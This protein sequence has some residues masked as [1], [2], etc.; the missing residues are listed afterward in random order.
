MAAAGWACAD[1]GYD[2]TWEPENAVGTLSPANDTRTNFILL[3][4]DR[5]GTKV[6]DPSAMRK[7][8]VP[9][10]FPYAVMIDRLTPARESE[11]QQSYETDLAG[12][13]LTENSDYF[14][15]DSGFLALCHS[16][17]SGAAQFESAL[18]ADA[19]VPAA[20]KTVL[21]SSRQQIAKACDNAGEM[22]FDLSGV[23]TPEGRAFAHYLEGTRLFYAEVPATADSEFAAVEHPSS[24][25]LTETASYMRFRSLLSLAMKTSLG[26]YGEMVEP[27]KRDQAAISRAD[28]AR[29]QYLAAF[30]NGRYA[31]SAQNL[32]RR[33]AWL[34]GDKATLGAAYS[35][36]LQA[37][38]AAGQLP[39]VG[40]IEE[41][42]R[43]I[44]PSDNSAGV[45]D[46]SLLAV[47]DLMRLRPG[48]A[49]YDKERSCC[50][51]WLSRAELDAQKR[52]FASD[53]GLYGY[54][55]AG[56]AFYHRHQP[57]EVLSLI[58]DAAHQARFSYTQFSRQVLRGFAL[59]ALG[60][61]NARGFWLSLLPGA[62]QP[63]QR[64]VVELAIFQ[65][66]KKA[67]VVGRLLET[68]SP[69]LHP[70]IR[71]KVIEDDAGPDLLR[72]QASAGAT[73]QQ[74]EVA[75]YL[76]LANELHHGWYRE[77]LAD[78]KLVG[79]RKQPGPDDYSSS[80]SVADYDPKYV[81]ELG[82]PPLDVFADGG[83]DTLQAC[84]NIQITA[85]NLAADPAAI[86]PRLCLG[87]F[88]RK[89][90]L[91][92]WGE[93]YDGSSGLVLKSRNGFPGT[94]LQRIDIYRSVI[95][96]PQASADDKA[97]ALN[98][99]I[100]CYAPAGNS[101]C[102]IDQEDLK[103]RK[104][105]YLELKSK[106]PDSPWAKDLKTYW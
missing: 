87:E 92:G 90:G 106:Y 54:L 46:P 67:G 7:G 35:A 69:I 70:L 37:R 4:A 71:Q 73:Q 58:P 53:P 104:A 60:D 63:Y 34:R 56:E 84:P 50:G 14:A 103:V 32:K 12:Y 96:S 1:G 100:R 95:A 25:W 85:A 94:P 66:D 5:Y 6:E 44:L 18:N 40:T 31:V 43:R 29:L 75:L 11:E 24:D 26:E 55:L 52:Y 49:Q 15:S 28:T 8:I 42:D 51:A 20:E 38:R 72:R 82:S 93:Q 21:I 97:F 19:A 48:D 88:I 30:P 39:D 81:T 80:W 2:T 62:V 13:G 64:D 102:G 76:L 17:R 9:I 23:I 61:R 74:R 3:M 89:K 22:K 16:N 105:R 59:E 68:G 33:I 79:A 77:F 83:S 10:E 27:A 47:T 36:M 98:R 45:T 101:S 41:V 78:Q 57:K 91:D 99:A 86:R 65:H